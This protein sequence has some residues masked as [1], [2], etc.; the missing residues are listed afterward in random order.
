VNVR[1]D[2][3][4]F[5]PNGDGRNDETVIDFAVANVVKTKTLRLNIF[6]LNGKKVKTISDVRTGIYPFYG[7]PRVGGRGILWDGKNDDGKTVLPGVYLLQISIDTDNGGEFLT[8][9]IVVSY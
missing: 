1:I 3:N 7:D 6:D 2:P 4:P 5:T 8:K 9:T